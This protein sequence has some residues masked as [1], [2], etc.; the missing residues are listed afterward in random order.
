MLTVTILA[1]LVLLL[2]LVHAKAVKCM[3]IP[4]IN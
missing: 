3:Q 4:Y 1:F 2:N